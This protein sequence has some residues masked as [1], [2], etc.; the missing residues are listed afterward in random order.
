M[1]NDGVFVRLL[2][3]ESRHMA[4]IAAIKEASLVGRTTTEHDAVNTAIRTDVTMTRRRWMTGAGA[5]LGAVALNRGFAFA[6]KATPLASPVAIRRDWQ[7]ERWIGSWAAAPHIPSPGLEDFLPSQIVELDG[8]T[9]RQFA[10][11]SA[12]GEQVR[13]RLSN[14]FGDAPILIG[15]AHVAL[16]NDETIDPASDRVVTFSGNPSIAI[17]SGALVLS[18]PVDLAVSPLGELAVSLYFPEPTTSTTVHGFALQTNHLSSPGDFTGDA[19]LPIA[20][21]LE[22]W[23][24]LTGIDV[25]VAESAAVVVALG[26]SITDGTGSTPD[27]NHRWPD[28]LA[29]RLASAESLGPAGVLNAGIGGNRLLADGAGDFSFAGPGALARLDRDVLAQAGVT[30]LIVFEGINDIGFAAMGGEGVEPVTAGQLITAL[31]QIAERAHE[32]GIVVFGATIT[33]FA[34]AMYYTPEGETTRQ[35]VNA[36]IRDGGAFDAVL[37]FDAIVRDPA[38]PGSLLPAYDAGDNLHITDAGY[39]AMAAS[40]DLALF[41]E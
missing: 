4:A 5:L 26:D 37:D 29:E 12:G 10:R 30:H 11:L 23:L 25:A 35:A 19:E 8:L 28:L 38:N 20:T 16:R 14:L 17:P 22:S 9:L 1:S 6:Q 7:R 34:G 39:Q 32:Q 24:F 31:R 33:P 27:A 13:I 2:M 40:I 41:A 18:D 21:T 36:W 15:A 3:N